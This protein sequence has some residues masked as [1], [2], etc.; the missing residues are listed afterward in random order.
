MAFICAA[1]RHKTLGREKDSRGIDTLLNS[2]KSQR[3]SWRMVCAMR[4][5]QPAC[6]EI[7]ATL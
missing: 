6:A 3:S 4:S 2:L 5:A 7:S 1:L